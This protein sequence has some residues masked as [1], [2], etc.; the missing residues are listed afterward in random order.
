MR[1]EDRAREM[2]DEAGIPEAGSTRLVESLA[3][4]GRSVDGI[5]PRPGPELSSLLA[6]SATGAVTP[7]TRRRARLLVATAVAISTV[8]AGGIAAAA[9]ELPEGAQNL[10]SRFSERYLPFDLPR[11]DTARGDR[12]TRF[13]PARQT[14]PSV[15]ESDRVGG[16]PALPPAGEPPAAPDPDVA[17]RE[18]SVPDAT[19]PPATA[20]SPAVPSQS[21]ASPAPTP[22]T[23]TAPADGGEVS[24]PGAAEGLET[25]GEPVTEPEL[26]DAPAVEEP[27]P[28]VSPD[29]GAARIPSSRRADS[30]AS[31][32]VQEKRKGK[33]RGRPSP[34]RAVADEVSAP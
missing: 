4:L 12:E 11:A 14:P 7:F 1:P 20:P 16:V 17:A 13:G 26:T 6:R 22:P 31:A 19:K 2:L 25:G 8:G 21:A 33:G 24:A 15:Q 34:P 18:V 32:N 27:K 3:T 29:T 23:Q 10:V 5:E 28:T 30:P 9:N